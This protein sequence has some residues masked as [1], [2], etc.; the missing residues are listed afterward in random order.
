M[1]SSTCAIQSL[2]KRCWFCRAIGPSKRIIASTQGAYFAL[3]RNSGSAQFW[4]PQ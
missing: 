2:A 1:S 4:L 3:T